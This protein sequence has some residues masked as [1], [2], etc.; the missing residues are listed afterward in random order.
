MTHVRATVVAAHFVMLADANMWLAVCVETLGVS[1][2]QTN[3]N[4]P[5]IFLYDG[6]KSPQPKEK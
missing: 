1:I 2:L 6:Q 4:Y 3:V 5:H